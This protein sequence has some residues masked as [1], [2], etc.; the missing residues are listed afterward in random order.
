MPNQVQN[1]GFGMGEYG[2]EAADIEPVMVQTAAEELIRKHFARIDGPSGILAQ[3]EL[4]DN[5]MRPKWQQYDAG[6]NWILSEDFQ[7]G[8][9]LARVACHEIGH[10]LGLEHD[11]QSSGS[12]MAP[13]IQ[14]S[15]RKPT[16]RDIQRLIGLGYKKRTTPIPDP[17][18]TIG[19]KPFTI[20]IT[21]QQAA[22]DHGGIVLGSPMGV[23]DYAYY[24]VNEGGLTPNPNP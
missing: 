12:L 7:G 19:P 13:Y 5:T 4:A 23:G 16:P 8:M 20:R 6:D 17:P 9:D 14:E 1:V 2:A 11:S 18:P 21:S 15:V 10:V 24:Q 22:G 3:S